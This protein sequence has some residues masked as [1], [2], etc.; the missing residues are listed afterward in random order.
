MGY[1]THSKSVPAIALYC[2]NLFKLLSL[3]LERPLINRLGGHFQ[4]IKTI[5][6]GPIF[7][8]LLPFWSVAAVM[9]FAM[10]LL[11]AHCL[12]SHPRG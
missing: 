10:F 8:S 6:G 1:L 11:R 4:F 9:T 5:L 7:Q 2:Y 12:G 3:K